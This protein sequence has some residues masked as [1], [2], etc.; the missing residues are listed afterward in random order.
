[1]V[2]VNKLELPT[3]FIYSRMCENAAGSMHVDLSYG[4]LNVC[5]YAAIV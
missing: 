1:V 3:H 4:K 5:N 2:Q